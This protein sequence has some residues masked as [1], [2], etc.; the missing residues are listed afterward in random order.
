MKSR[1]RGRAYCA[2]LSARAE[3]GVWATV[4]AL[5]DDLEAEGLAVRR[6]VRGDRRL[7]AVV[8]TDKGRQLHNVPM[9]LHAGMR[10]ECSPR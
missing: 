5:I 4:A 10:L 6:P 8:L 3:G 9:L 2:V 1:P 7:R